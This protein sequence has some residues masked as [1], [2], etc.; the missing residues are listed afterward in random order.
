MT[1]KTCLSNAVT[2]AQLQA[3][4]ARGE[5]V[6]GSVLDQ[7]NQLAAAGHPL[8]L[9]VV[10]PSA[11]LK[12]EDGTDSGVALMIANS[13]INAD[14]AEL[15]E[16]CSGDSSEAFTARLLGAT[17]SIPFIV[18]HAINRAVANGDQEIIQHIMDLT[19]ALKEYIGDNDEVT[20]SLH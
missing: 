13:H 12:D 1:K 2:L 20:L 19:D 4:K 8:F 15:R 18:A 14:L 3:I 9:Q 11:A 6:G 17:T 7:I 10:V 5:A 16:L